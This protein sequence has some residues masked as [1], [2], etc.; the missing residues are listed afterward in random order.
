MANVDF[1]GLTIEAD[2]EVAFH[3]EDIK[4]EMLTAQ[5]LACTD[6]IRSQVE[7]AA[8]KAGV[9]VARFAV[10]QDKAAGCCLVEVRFRRPQGP[11]GKAAG[12]KESKAK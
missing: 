11:A 2:A 7:S 6:G 8:K 4:P 9:E 3:V 1:S 5:G 10:S 12:E